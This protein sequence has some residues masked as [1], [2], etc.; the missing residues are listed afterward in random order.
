MQPDGFA[1]H[2]AIMGDETLMLPPLSIQ[3]KWRPVKR[4]RVFRADA[5]LRHPQRGRG[6]QPLPQMGMPR[7]H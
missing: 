1:A 6:A 3:D 2:V 5:Q 4:M 7:D